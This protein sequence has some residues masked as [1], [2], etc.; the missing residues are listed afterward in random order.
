[1]D[2]KRFFLYAIAIAALA[3]AG[4]GGNGGNG[5]TPTPGGDTLT[6]GAGT[7]E[8][9]GACVPTVP[10]GM[11]D[12]DAEDFAP[13]I[14]KPLVA[15]DGSMTF[16]GM[17]DRDNP[18][19]LTLNVGATVDGANA[20]SQVTVTDDSNAVTTPAFEAAT[21][22]MPLDLNGAEADVFAGSSFGRTAQEAAAA[23]EADDTAD[24]VVVAA[25]AMPGIVDYVTVYTDVEDPTMKPF[26]D[27]YDL[28]EG[29]NPDDLEDDP[30][31]ELR[32]NDTALMV[33][34][35]NVPPTGTATFSMDEDDT[36][37]GTYA[38]VSG[39]YRCNSA[40][41]SVTVEDDGV[42]GD[43][44]NLVFVPG[45][46][47]APEEDDDY[48]SFGYWVRATTT[49]DADDETSTS[50]SVATFANGEMAY[51]AG[52]IEN[53]SGQATYTGS[54]TGLYVQKTDL[55]A[56]DKGLV[57]TSTGQ[58]T[59][60]VNLDATFG[61]PGTVGDDFHQGIS[62]TVEKFKN[63][64]GVDLGWTLTLMKAGITSNSNE[65]MGATCMGMMCGGADQPPVGGWEGQFFGSSDSDPDM[66]G[67]QDAE[68]DTYPM[69][70]AG[71]FNGHFDG[72]DDGPVGHVLGAFGAHLD[73]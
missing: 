15:N 49:T 62:G 42:P 72:S 53:L 57:P 65:Y 66:D 48:L 47:M 61:T 21:T 68:K 40:T 31:T 23:V 19:A 37:T 60:N 50:Y 7:M 64:A 34:T 5:M 30:H 69:S 3:L 45:D 39:M 16:D 8:V 51:T 52:Q 10:I 29:G 38:G 14:A 36:I 71:R 63:G 32:P 27:I 70:T 25:E 12:D 59:A 13:A 35:A 33:L 18:A 22:H 26:G 6:C 4:C 41:C 24:P 28:N 1:M 43:V 58:F 17:L 56:D 54:A 73:E 2:M 20:V 46:A 9:S 11:A 44:Y 55:H 67:M